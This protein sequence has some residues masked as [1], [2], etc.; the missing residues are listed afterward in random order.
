VTDA[1]G[2]ARFLEEAAHDVV[3]RL[4]LGVEDLERDL[5]LE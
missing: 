5:A 1:C 2:E 3:A 4:V